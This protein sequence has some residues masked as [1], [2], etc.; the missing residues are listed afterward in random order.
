MLDYIYLNLLNLP[1]SIFKTKMKEQ[2]IEEKPLGYDLCCETF[3][4]EG[5]LIGKKKSAWTFER[6]EVDGFGTR[7]E[8]SAY[9]T[10]GNFGNFRPAIQLSPKKSQT[11]SIVKAFLI[12]HADTGTLPRPLIYKDRIFIYYPISQYGV[13]LETLR[14]AKKAGSTLYCSY[15]LQPQFQKITA[16]VYFSQSL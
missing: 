10:S 12:F 15:L 3:D 16:G 2:E 14:D 11:T 6:I 1:S 8:I 13:I 7:S 9:T 4:E 5:K